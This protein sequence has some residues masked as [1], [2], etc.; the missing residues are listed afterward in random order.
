MK[1]RNII[2]ILL[3]AGLSACVKPT[4]G[5]LIRVDQE[6]SKLSLEKGMKFAFLQ[7][8]ADSAVLLQ[9]NALPV[10]GKKSHC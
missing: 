10:V 5:D 3:A 7:Y 1:H 8:A 6:F 4:S 2:F 9:K